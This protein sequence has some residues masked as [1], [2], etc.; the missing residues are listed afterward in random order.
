MLLLSTLRSGGAPSASVLFQIL[1]LT[2]FLVSSIGFIK[3]VWFISIGYGYGIAATAVVM[4]AYVL[5]CSSGGD[6]VLDAP[7]LPLWAQLALLV[8]YG[9]RLGTHVLRRERNAHYQKAAKESYGDKNRASLSAKFAVWV[10]VA[11]LYVAMVSPAAFHLLHVLSEEGGNHQIQWRQEQLFSSWSQPVG[12]AIMTVGLIVE[13]LADRQKAAA[14]RR[15]PNRF[16]DKQL[17]SWV[18]CP[19]YFGEILFW[20]GNFIAPAGSCYVIWWH[21]V[22]SLFGLACLTSIML[23]ST[24]RL[25]AN[26]QKRYGRD[27]DYVVYVRKVPVLFP[28][29]PIY[30]LQGLKYT[31]G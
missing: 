14:K 13:G 12:L 4:G 29:V 15:N 23:G 17:Y 18:R 21:W 7:L 28:F 3:L 2:S 26:Q 22:L 31:L 9:L 30:S 10:S 24:K 27:P 11:P 20:V 6:S 1:L 25:E 8:A 16:C 19:N 5:R